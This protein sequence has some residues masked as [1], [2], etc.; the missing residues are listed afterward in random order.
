MFLDVNIKAQICKKPDFLSLVCVCD[1]RTFFFLAELLFLPDFH[2]RIL[3]LRGIWS[4]KGQFTA[5]LLRLSFTK[6]SG[7][8][9]ILL[10]ALLPSLLFARWLLSSGLLIF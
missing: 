2:C 5:V 7:S 10:F 6:S 3:F 9:L 1:E 8:I 4:V